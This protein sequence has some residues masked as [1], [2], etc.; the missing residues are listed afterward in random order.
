MPDAGRLDVYRWVAPL[1]VGRRVLDVRCGPG[2]GAELLANAGSSEVVGVD[3]FDG[4]TGDPL[5]GPGTGVA[6]D[7]GRPG[8]LEHADASFQLV[9]AIGPA[10]A[11]HPES[12]LLDELLRVTASDGLL[13]ISAPDGR[14]GEA[15]Q[16]RLLTRF[17][18]VATARC[19]TLIGSGVLPRDAVRDQ[20]GQVFQAEVLP[21]DGDGDGAEEVFLLAGDPGPGGLPPT[22][23]VEDA[24]LVPRWM[25]SWK[26]QRAEEEALQDRVRELEQRL[27]ECDQLH[28]RLRSAQQALAVR[29]ATADE[30]VQEAVGEIAARFEA[31][32]GWRLT[33]PLRRAL[34][35]DKRRL[36]GS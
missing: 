3:L 30:A 15:L 14:P 31:T 22:R 21:Q 7:G 9:V 8:R 33:A 35:V 29:I 13:L 24:T 26:A 34:P 12:V 1:A 32:L 36:R 4:R 19:R 17:G 27:A 2:D 20:P 23:L 18:R 16:E 28:R 5:D 25:E 6:V 11:K 10:V